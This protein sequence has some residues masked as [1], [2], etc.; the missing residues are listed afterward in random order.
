MTLRNATDNQ[1][2]KA[3]SSPRAQKAD[4]RIG[5]VRPTPSPHTTPY[6]HHHHHQ[7]QQQQQQQQQRQEE[8][9]SWVEKG[10]GNGLT[11]NIGS[12]AF[13]HHCDRGAISTACIHLP[14]SELNKRITKNTVIQYICKYMKNE[15]AGRGKLGRRT[16]GG[17]NSVYR[18]PT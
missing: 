12:L 7:P 13:R 10:E 9:I 17:S 2:L 5:K 11:I 1:F 3:D 6:H 14:L 18:V 16:L 8:E 15:K 4:Q